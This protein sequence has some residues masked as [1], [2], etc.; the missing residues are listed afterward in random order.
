MCN[1]TFKGN[2]STP[3]MMPKYTTTCSLPN[4]ENRKPL[5]S[6]S[7]DRDSL[8]SQQS[9]TQIITKNNG[10][11]FTI[12]ID[13]DPTALHLRYQS[14]LERVRRLALTVF[15][16]CCVIFNVRFFFFFVQLW[17]DHD[18]VAICRKEQIEPVDLN[19]CLKAFTSEEK[20]EQ[21]YHCSHCKGKKPATKK[22]QIW[23]LPPILVSLLLSVLL[24]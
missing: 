21:W 9:T 8:Q 20:L 15:I 18:T 14:T 3:K 4:L 7:S 12:A 22:L 13:W 24:I 2:S 6:N 17:V 1:K 5:G 11:Y 10:D 16:Y 19:H 23:K